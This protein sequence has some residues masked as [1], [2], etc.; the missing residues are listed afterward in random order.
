[1]ENLKQ[2][3]MFE[4]YLKEQNVET[5]TVEKTEEVN[6]G[7]FGNS[8]NAS[9]EYK[10]LNDAFIK[11]RESIKTHDS[12]YLI[13]FLGK[14]SI[15]DCKVMDAVKFTNKCFTS[16]KSKDKCLLI[17][18]KDLSILNHSAF[19]NNTGSILDKCQIISIKDCTPIE[20]IGFVVHIPAYIIY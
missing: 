6:E 11:V 2:V 17:I 3:K 18:M 10:S 15:E 13:D 4:E 5:E 19:S 16:N 14:E 1:M 12:I 7:L 8:N 20:A 9:I